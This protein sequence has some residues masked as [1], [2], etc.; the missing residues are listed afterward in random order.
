MILNQK[1]SLIH[2]QTNA[3]LHYMIASWS[4]DFWAYKKMPFAGC[5]LLHL[6]VKSGNILYFS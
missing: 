1:Q 4:L 6:K 2:T 5:C 3:A